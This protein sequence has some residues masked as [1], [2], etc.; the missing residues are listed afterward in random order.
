MLKKKFT[1]ILCA[2]VATFFLL[3]VSYFDLP[4]V[5]KQE[6]H[7]V[8]IA[9]STTPLSTPFY[10]AKAINAFDDTCVNV[11]YQNVTGGQA[12]F[13]RVMNGKVDFA[14]SSDSVI[15]FESLKPQSFVTHAMFVQSDND[16][17]L[18]T[19]SA[20][21]IAAIAD[22]KGK[23]IGVTKGTASEYILTTL[24]AIEGLTI[25]DIQLRN[26]SPEKLIAGFKRHEVDAILPWEPFV[27]QAMQAFGDEIKIHDT[28]S[29]STL[30]FNLISQAG[31]K[32]L[33]DKAECVIQGL[34]TAIHYIT[35]HP[36]Q[37]KNI[38]IAELNVAPEFI[39]WVWPD[40]IFK[41]GLNQSLI[42]NV[43]A[44]ASWAIGA[45]MTTAVGESNA[46][47]FIDSR[48]LL[49]VD[50]GAVNISL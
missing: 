42:L 39:D 40:Y 44:Q 13:E 28:K 20:D 32:L 25:D 23:R 14:T 46:V 21:D 45:Q 8:T 2:L 48:A 3:C 33:V 31:E 26:Y 1:I 15:A 6:K 50:S 36:Q 19:R 17:K 41:L 4:Q 37:A 38:V 34:H 11:E 43:N 5:L 7:S 47:N 29:L 22:L 30:S 10:V 16:V 27:F 12:A 18:I 9:V 24:L 35:S 49:R